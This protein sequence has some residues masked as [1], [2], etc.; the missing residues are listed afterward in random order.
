MCSKLGAARSKH[1]PNVSLSNLL[2][3]SEQLKLVPYCIPPVVGGEIR[4]EGFGGVGGTGLNAYD[5]LRGDRL[6][7]KHT[8]RLSMVRLFGFYKA[9]VDERYVILLN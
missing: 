6:V 8:G 7:D 1:H 2:V 5:T 3:H 9:Q 4:S